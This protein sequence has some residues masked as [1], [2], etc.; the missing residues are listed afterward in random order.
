MIQVVV[1]RILVCVML[2]GVSYGAYQVITSP[3][4]SQ[5]TDPEADILDIQIGSRMDDGSLLPPV[6]LRAY[7]EISKS[8]NYVRLII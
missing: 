7:V 2:M 4:P 8:I 3:D 5:E 1:H 6:Q